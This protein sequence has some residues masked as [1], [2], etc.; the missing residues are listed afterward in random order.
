MNPS[1]NDPLS[2]VVSQEQA[3][4]VLAMQTGL[5]RL[6]YNHALASGT[7]VER[8]E[9]INPLQ[10]HARAMARETHRE[11]F[12]PQ[13]HVHDAMHQ[14]EYERSLAQRED[15]ERGEQHAVANLREA[16][17]AVASAPKAGPKP[18]LNSWLLGAFIV[19]FSITVAPTL[20]DSVFHT[21]P[22]D[23]LAW[24]VS[25]ICSAFVGAMLSWGILGGR[26]TKLTWIGAAAGVALGIG[27][28]A[29][30]LSS[31]EN[32]GEGMFAVG[33]TIVEIAAVLLLEFLAR[34]LRIKE[35]EWTVDHA[36]ESEALARHDACQQDLARR[37]GRVKE[38][39]QA[40]IEKIALV[41]D[42]F[43]RNI[44]IEELEQAAVKAVRDGYSRGVAE[45]I[46]RIHGV[47]GR[48]R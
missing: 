27:L 4:A 21:L 31:A 5:Y 42:R 2:E 7:T 16:E 14:A 18:R 43:N 26:R 33:L 48:T 29:V 34:D 13:E 9:D 36:K 32:A 23:L 37:Q 8:P 10:D 45:N 24:F 35:A 1:N 46:G 22:D 17:Q 19:V 38:K 47:S 11:T 20:H 30:R 12:D 44:H 3:G 41:E 6:G 25:L 40:V 39:H 15:A 28:L